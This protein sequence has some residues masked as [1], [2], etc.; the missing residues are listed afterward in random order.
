MISSGSAGL[1]AYTLFPLIRCFSWS[2]WI[3]LKHLSAFEV[4]LFAEP[5]ISMDWIVINNS[6]R[7]IIRTSIQQLKFRSILPLGCLLSTAPLRFWSSFRLFSLQKEI[8]WM[9][10]NRAFVFSAALSSI[11]LHLVVVYFCLKNSRY[12]RFCSQKNCCFLSFKI[13]SKAYHLLW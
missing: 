13:C 4:Y 9:E 8:A 2:L 3:P 12:F 10:A 1:H 5:N 11:Q 6:L 7:V